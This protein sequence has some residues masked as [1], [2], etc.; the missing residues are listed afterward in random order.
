MF[1]RVDRRTWL[2]STAAGSLLAA[3]PAILFAQDPAGD[4][5]DC[6]GLGFLPL[7]KRRPY[8]RVEG[9]GGANAAESVPH[10]F[11]PKCRGDRN[12]Q[13]LV[14]EETERLKTA[15]ENHRK[16]EKETG[17]ALKRVETR[18]IMVHAQMPVAECVKIGQ[19]FE[20]LAA[21]LQELT[22][23]MELTRTRPDTYEQM[24][25]FGPEAYAHFRTVLEKLYSVDERGPSWSVSRG[26]SAFD[27]TLIPFFQ[28]S[29]ET[30]KNRPPVHGVCFMGGRKQLHVATN[31]RAPKWLAEGF[32][33][34][35]EFAALKKNLWRTVY[36]QKE[37][38]TPGDWVSQLR[39]FAVDKNLRP[40]VEQV[41]RDIRDWDA[42]DYLQIFGMT[43]FLLQT[44]PKKFLV[45]V[46]NLR[47]AAD[48]TTALE[49]AYGKSIANLEPECNRWLIRGGK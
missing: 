41:E 2:K 22:G 3:C 37:G 20:N 6:G 49:E 15:L 40:W 7:K 31:N 26:L 24:S 38:P 23:S 1:S 21:H 42:R 47:T 27:H 48:P 19:G 8:F 25:L 4:C 18:H 29:A 28:E 5:P 45:Y 11:C 44:E 36:N 34:Y 13:E 10:R 16:W 32:A 43:A 35:C 17:F 46:R 39:K 33:E 12:E 9:Q 30:I 14:D